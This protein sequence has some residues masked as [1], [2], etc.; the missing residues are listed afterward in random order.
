MVYPCSWTMEELRAV[1]ALLKR[2]EF[3]P[4]EIQD[5]LHNGKENAKLTGD[6]MKL[7]MLTLPFMVRDL[8]APEVNAI[9]PSYTRV[10]PSITCSY[11]GRSRSSMQLLIGQGLARGF[12]AYRTSLTPVTR[13]WRSSSSSWCGILSV[14]GVDS[15]TQTLLGCK[16][17]LWSCWRLRSGT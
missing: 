5:D 9:Y 2:P 1:I 4:A 3:K 6:R 15:W 13:S 11:Y 14:V 8:I 17:W 12:T 16:K 7:L 10:M